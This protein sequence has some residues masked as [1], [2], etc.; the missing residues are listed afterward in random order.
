MYLKFDGV[1]SKVS[2]WG[3]K[4]D[5]ALSG[6]ST[7]NK[8]DFLN[9]VV[10]HEIISFSMSKRGVYDPIFKLKLSEW[11]ISLWPKI[12]QINVRGH[13]F[14]RDVITNLL[15]RATFAHKRIIKIVF[16]CDSMFV[17]IQC[18][19]LEIFAIKKSYLFLFWNS[20]VTPLMIN[21]SKLVEVK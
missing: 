10:T 2:H 17:D 19:P 7:F 9:R 21:C 14:Q 11:T 8:F 4:N 13:V 18:C 5:G 3:K 20:C 15:Q 16:S 12:A 1:F 6:L